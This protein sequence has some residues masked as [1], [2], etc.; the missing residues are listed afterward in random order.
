MLLGN[1]WHPVPEKILRLIIPYLL[2][3][4]QPFLQKNNYGKI[5]S[6]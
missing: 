5:N 2:E 3:N 4:N 6:T 1:A